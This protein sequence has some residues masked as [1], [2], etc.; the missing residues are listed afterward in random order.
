MPKRTLRWRYVPETCKWKAVI[1]YDGMPQAIFEVRIFDEPEHTQAYME[2]V[3]RFVGPE[4]DWMTAGRL[5]IERLAKG[6]N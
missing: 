5:S 6:V 2:S 4:P 1:C 3:A